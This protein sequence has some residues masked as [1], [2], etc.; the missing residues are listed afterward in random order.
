MAA[1]LVFWQSDEVC[2]TITSIRSMPSSRIFTF[3]SRQGADGAQGDDTSKLKP[4]VPDWVN[5]EWKPD[6]PVDPEDKHCR[7]FTNNACG[8]LLCPTELDWNNPIVRAGIRDCIDGHIV[9]EMSWPTFRYAGYTANLNNLKEGLFK[10]KLLV[11]VHHT[12]TEDIAGDEDGTNI[13]E[14]NRCAKKDVLGKKVKTHVAQIIKMHKVS[15][16][17]IAYVS[18]QLQF[19][20]SSVTSWQSVDGNFD[21]MQFWCNIVDFFEHPP[22]RTVQ[23]N[24]D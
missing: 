4:L 12:K 8:R 21:Y 24:M 23:H 5:C 2:T 19:T 13:I 10:S 6:P 15:P 17:L 7:G 3:A 11:Q 22:G 20:L 1:L 14:N 16:R 9:M 18:C